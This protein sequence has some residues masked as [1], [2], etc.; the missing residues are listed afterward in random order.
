MYQKY[1][2]IEKACKLFD[3]ML[4]ANTTSWIAMIAGYAQNWYVD[5][6]VELF[7]KMHNA[8]NTWWEQVGEES[9]VDSVSITIDGFLLI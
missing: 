3:K 4:H 2:S 7:D 1:G 9:K 8:N 6:V 5:R